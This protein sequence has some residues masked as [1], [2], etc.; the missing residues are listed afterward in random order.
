MKLLSVWCIVCWYQKF[1]KG[2]QFHF[3]FYLKILY[4]DILNLIFEAVTDNLGNQVTQNA[5]SNTI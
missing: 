1:K 4:V 3:V 2:N 5:V